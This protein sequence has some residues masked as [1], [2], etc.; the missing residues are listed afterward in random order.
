MVLDDPLTAIG[1]AA[2]V[3][4]VLLGALYLVDVPLKGK[5]WFGVL[6]L[7]V[8]VTI[9]LFLLRQPGLGGVTIATILALVAR[10]QLERRG[11]VD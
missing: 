9:L 1:V 4:F 10:E 6:F 7:L 5:R 8:G 2:I 3:F 11:I